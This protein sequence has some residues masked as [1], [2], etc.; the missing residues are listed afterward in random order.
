MTIPA[1]QQQAEEAPRS[2]AAPKAAREAAEAL[3][4]VMYSQKSRF[5]RIAS[6]LGLSMPQA[7]TLVHLEQPMSMGALAD[8]LS[9]DASNITGIVDKLE[10]RGLLQRHPSTE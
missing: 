4:Q 10:T 2:D 7:G 6:E 1:V 3:F 5:E 8:E 9:C